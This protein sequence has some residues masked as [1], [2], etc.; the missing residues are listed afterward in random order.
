MNVEVF[1]VYLCL[2]PDYKNLNQ[3]EKYPAILLFT[4]LNK[5]T[6]PNLKDDVCVLFYL[7]KYINVYAREEIKQAP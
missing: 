6:N 2:I 3:K 5:Y 1:I 4:F 7:V